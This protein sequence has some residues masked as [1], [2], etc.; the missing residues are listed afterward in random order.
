MTR[1]EPLDSVATSVMCRQFLKLTNVKDGLL[2]Q[3]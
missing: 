3:H 2:L 1:Y